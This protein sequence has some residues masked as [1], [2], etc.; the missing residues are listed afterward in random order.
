MTTET[1]ATTTAPAPE[2]AAA[3]TA[4]TPPAT[5]T[6]TAAAPA[7][8]EGATTT[9]PGATTTTPPATAATGEG[10]K[11]GETKPAT[12]APEKYEAFKLADGAL[13][14]EELAATETQA[15]ELG[16]SQEAA[17]KFA[18]LR[19]ADKAGLVQAQQQAVADARASWVAEVKADKVLGGDAL[20]E[21][22]AVAKAGL[23]ALD[24]DGAMQKLLETSG[25][26]DHPEVIRLF[27]RAGKALAPDRVVPGGKAP[28]GTR[29]ARS[30]YAASNMNP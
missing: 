1:T 8:T 12:G 25:M 11:S 18:E 21:N 10:D 22:L 30:F 24:P 9:T 7:G 16:L 4:A 28:N 6:T 3:T 17:Q 13:T 2:G 19:A 15:R 23:Q 5:S 29:D 20:T 27:H 26:G 14:A